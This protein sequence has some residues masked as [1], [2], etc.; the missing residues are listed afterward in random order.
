MARTTA[1]A[2]YRPLLTLDAWGDMDEDEPGELVDGV[3]EEEEMPSFLHEIIVLWLA[4]VLG[5]WA[6]RRGGRVAGSET[7]IAVGAR[8]GRKA[9]VS[10]FVQPDMPELDAAVVRVPPYL[11]VEVVSPRP[12]DAKR[13]RVEKPAD[14]AAARVRHYWIL[15]PKLRTLDLFTLPPRA[16]RYTHVAAAAT[17]RLRRIK[18]FPGLVLDLDALWKHVDSTSSPRARRTRSASAKRR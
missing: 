16:R 8:R 18:G 2:R 17:G 14:Y 9:D 4:A 12:R 11:L 13:D 15:D 5:A 1:V 7:K 10:V 6:H 3:L